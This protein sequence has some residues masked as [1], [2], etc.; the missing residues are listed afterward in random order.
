MKRDLWGRST[1]TILDDIVVQHRTI[2]KKSPIFARWTNKSTR[3]CHLLSSRSWTERKLP[4]LNKFSPK[5]VA[6]WKITQASQLVA[7]QART[8][9]GN[10]LDLGLACFLSGGFL[11]KHIDNELGGLT[12]FMC[13]PL[14]YQQH[15][16]KTWQIQQIQEV[17]GN[18]KFSDKSLQEFATTKYFL[19]IIEQRNIEV[20]LGIKY[21]MQGFRLFVWR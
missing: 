6:E 17:F 4:S 19:L 9:K 21:R 14:D 2:N 20:M 12:V 8:W 11:A 3:L 7:K 16:S 10:V 18:G 15:K 5:L 1:G 13:C